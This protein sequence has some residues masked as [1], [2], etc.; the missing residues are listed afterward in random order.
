MAGDEGTRDTQDTGKDRRP[1]LNQLEAFVAVVEHRSYAKAGRE[2]DPETSSSLL[3]RTID[4]L[5]KNLHVEL[6]ETSRG[7]RAVTPTRAGEILYKEAQ[8][9]L[10]AADRFVTRATDVR[11]GNLHTIRL[12]CSPAHLRGG[13]AAGIKAFKKHHPR[14]TVQLS[15]V[16]EDEQ[17]GGEAL[18]AEVLRNELDLVIVPARDEDPGE[19]AETPLYPWWLIALFPPGETPR[20]RLLRVHDLR[21]R[22]LLVRTVGFTRTVFS[23]ECRRA[24]FKPRIAYEVPSDDAILSLHAHGHGVA[25]IPHDVVPKHLADTDA[26]RPILSHKKIPLGGTFMMYAR[27]ADVDADP[28]LKS[29][30]AALEK[31]GKK[32]VSPAGRW[33]QKHAPMEVQR[34]TNIEPG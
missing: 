28:A 15:R 8:V 20:K 30:I 11:A 5:Q 18:F 2:A 9:V 29:L 1:T 13:V 33:L 17:G 25:L 12:G 14:V 24:G 10:Q 19:F 6:L 34:H 23:R 16:I 4:R 22:D 21:D 7:E 3:W 31:A 32:A 26:V 27:Q